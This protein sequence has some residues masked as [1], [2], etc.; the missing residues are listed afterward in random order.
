[1]LIGRQLFGGFFIERLNYHSGL[2][3]QMLIEMLY[4]NL[5]ADW[6]LQVFYYMRHAIGR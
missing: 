5:Y 3:Y 2:N 1:M 6:Q 4:A